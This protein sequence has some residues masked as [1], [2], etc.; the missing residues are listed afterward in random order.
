MLGR[1]MLLKLVE[2]SWWSAQR[3]LD[4]TAELSGEEQSSVHELFAPLSLWDV[5]LHAA[6]VESIWR[7]LGQHGELD[8]A[9][10]PRLDQVDGVKGLWELW[11]G[12][13]EKLKDW[14]DGL[15]SEELE[16]RV[17]LRRPDGGEIVMARWQMLMQ[18]FTH[19]IQH[20]SEA[21]AM[22]TG[23]GHSPGNLDFVFFV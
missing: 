19:S 4:K 7:L 8:P 16:E 9:L 17:T 18:L 20:R 13:N 11:Q 2:Y 21:A 14:V 23:L 10:L 15:S 5:L 6:R 12:E 22:L 1:E 3:L